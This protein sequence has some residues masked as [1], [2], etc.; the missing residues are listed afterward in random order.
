MWAELRARII[1]STVALVLVALLL[2]FAAVSWV[3][4]I[5]GVGVL[6]IVGVGL[7]EY[8]RL[9]RTKNY[10]LP[11][12]FAIV[13]S[14]LYVVVVYFASQ[15]AISTFW[16][17]AA[18]GLLFLLFFIFFF[19]SK[20]ADRMGPLAVTFFGFF[21]VAVGFSTFL[22]T[23]YL[24]GEGSIRVGQWWVIFIILVTVG[25]DIGAYFIGKGFGR[26]K[27][28]P[29]LSPGKTWAG[30]IGGL[31]VAL[32]IGIVMG[33]FGR[34]FHPFLYSLIASFILGVIGQL[35]DLAESLLKRDAGVKDSNRL[36][37]LGGVL[38][39]VDGLLFTIPVGFAMQQLYFLIGS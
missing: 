21:Y 34:P 2:A 5:I 7:W 36:P 35:G 6:S 32:V 18:I 22:N 26:R 24:N 13:V 19:A 15:G 1:W 30:A 8:Y 3:R 29:H 12:R 14:L 39:V 4:P 11:D 10:S 17:M 23:L 31:G 9:A 38:D 25:T 37:G 33:L 20:T 28:A 16:Q 27:L